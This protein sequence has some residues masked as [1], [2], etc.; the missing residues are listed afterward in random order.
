MLSSQLAYAQ[1]RAMSKEAGSNYEVKTTHEAEKVADARL[2]NSLG[3]TK[4]LSEVIVDQSVRKIRKHGAHR[5]HIS[6]WA[7]LVAL[8]EPSSVE[9]AES[10]LL[11]PMGMKKKR[12][13]S[14]SVRSPCPRPSTASE[15]LFTLRRLA[16]GVLA[17][18]RTDSIA[19]D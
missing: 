17:V 5:P 10:M 15:A 6:V 2:M 8:P 18:L 16:A 14:D 13:T 9:A 11:T 1:W 4:V 3:I 7:V 12:L 19:G